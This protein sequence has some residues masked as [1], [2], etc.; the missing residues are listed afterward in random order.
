[1]CLPLRP[2]QISYRRPAQVQQALSALL[3]AACDVQREE[4]L[5]HDDADVARQVLA[6]RARAAVAAEAGLPR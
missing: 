3:R 1:M 4:T 2:R 5:H 6:N